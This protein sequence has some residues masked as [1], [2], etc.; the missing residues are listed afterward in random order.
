MGLFQDSLTFELFVFQALFR[1]VACVCS[2]VCA[3]A[4]PCWDRSAHG[5]CLSCTIMF[6]YMLSVVSQ[7][8]TPKGMWLKLERVG[9]W[10]WSL[11]SEHNKNDH[12]YR[13][14]VL[15]PQSAI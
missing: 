14:L 5:V 3:T 13:R 6:S 9:N 12:E 10:R 11:A 8:L 15:G 7:V 4:E 1:S 2:T